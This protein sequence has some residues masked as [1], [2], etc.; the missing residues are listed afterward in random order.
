MGTPRGTQ[1]MPIP[2][3]PAGFIGV[4]REY[5]PYTYE[6][7]Y[8]TT[9]GEGTPWF[10]VEVYKYFWL[11]AAPDE[12]D[13][14]P[15]YRCLLPRFHLYTRDPNECAAAGGHVESVLG[16]IGTGPAWNRTPLYRMY[17]PVTGDHFYTADFNERLS[18]LQ[19]GF[20][21]EMVVGYVAIGTQPQ[22]P[23]SLTPPA[24]WNGVSR[25]YAP[26]TNEHFYTTAPWEGDGWY[27]IEAYN[28]Y[29]VRAANDEPALTPWYRCLAWKHFYTA[30]ANECTNAGGHIEAVMGY[31]GTYPAWNRTPLYRMYNA[32]NG[33]FFYTT[34]F[35]ERLS[36][37]VYGYTYQFVAGYVAFSPTNPTFVPSL[38][39]WNGVTRKWAPENNEH[40][41]TTTLWE[42]DG[43][44]TPEAY[45]YFFLRAA[46]D[47]PNLAP[48]YRCML[49][50][51]HFYTADPNEC[52]RASGH[53]ESLMGYIGTTPAWHRWPLYR[54][55]SWSTGDHFYTVDFNELGLAATK[56]GYS[57]EFVAGYVSLDAQPPVNYSAP[58]GWQGVDRMYSPFGTGEHFYTV[59]HGE[60]LGWFNLEAVNYYYLRAANDM[61][62]LT[63]FYRCLIGSKHFY[64]ANAQECSNAGGHVESS[65]GYISTQPQTGLAPLYRLYNGGSYDHFY[66]TS[67]DERDTAAT[68]YGYSY[69]GIAGYVLVLW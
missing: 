22:L 26:E 69:E 2:P 20:R 28:Y 13:V 11:R 47:E 17:S 40:F 32:N 51:K 12:P 37:T 4:D 63:P 46:P 29:Y 68:N 56:Y 65:L 19:Y 50:T 25:R 52:T 30:D 53:V 33:D 43:W 36:A 3:P 34:D 62:S 55:V 45:N 10:N 61:P 42:G 39:G 24:G 7:F 8:T 59:S 66:T 67:A 60:G 35:N 31:I 44:Y 23:G 1:M 5:N 41:Y 14:V 9:H 54:M 58:A 21:F 49:P 18:V 16:Y 27:N 57:F 64:S 48:W 38:P 6:H 15:L